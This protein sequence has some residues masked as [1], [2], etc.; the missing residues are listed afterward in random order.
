MC[1]WEFIN[2]GSIILLVR[3]IFLFLVEKFFLGC[4]VM[5]IILFV[6]GL[7][8]IEIFFMNVFFLGLKRRE[9]CM[10]NVVDGIVMMIEWG[11]CIFVL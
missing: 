10:W 9:V 3:L 1:V 11:I 5:F 6:L 2:L 4:L 8:F 7:I